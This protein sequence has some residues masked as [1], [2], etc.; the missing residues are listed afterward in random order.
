[1]TD[2][3]LDLNQLQIDLDTSNLALAFGDVVDGDVNTPVDEQPKNP[4]RSLPYYGWGGVVSG[5]KLLA[6]CQSSADV[7]T[8][9]QHDYSNTISSS[10]L[11]HEHL[12]SNVSSSVERHTHLHAYNGA[13]ELLVQYGYAITSADRQLHTYLYAQNGLDLLLVSCVDVPNSNSSMITTQLH[14]QNHGQMLIASHAVAENGTHISGCLKMSYGHGVQPPCNWREIPLDDKPKTIDYPCGKHPSSDNLP[15]EFDQY[16]TE[17]DS[18][19]ISFPFA[20]RA[21]NFIPNLTTYIMLNEITVTANG[22]T[23]TPFSASISASM[24]GYC[25]LGEVSLPPDDFAAL[26]LDKRIQGDELEIELTLNGEKF[27]FLAEQF[28]DSRQFGRKS[29]TVSGRS[30]TAHLG[31]DYAQIQNGVVNQRFYAQQIASAVLY[32]TSFSLGNWTAVDWL[33]P[34]NVYSLS[35]KTPIAVLQDIA[36]AAGAF[37]E[38]DP[39]E[40]KI[41]IAPR[42]KKA[43]WE[44]VD[45]VVDVRCPADIIIKISGQKQV[46]TQ[47][48]SVFTYPTH[49]L[50]DAGLVYRSGS[51]KMPQAPMLSHALYTESNVQRAAGLATL[52]ESGVHKT[53][54]V[55]LAPPSEKYAIPRAKLGQIWR[56]DEPDGAWFGVVVGVKLSASVENGAPKIT[57]TLTVDRYL[58][59]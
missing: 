15:F 5:S 40:R 37:L 27:V 9:I 50:N 53:E 56:F 54:T 47:Y 8:A 32:D 2:F 18:A 25:W 16:Q 14:G 19:H 7:D 57:Q 20:C 36:Q 13:N 35:D 41:H 49:E 58:G 59:D 26:A 6:H 34:E 12:L 38:S 42:W 55:E 23:L 39:S 21:E 1:M 4:R 28:S 29:Y 11:V 44:L 48:R 30:P 31:A 46:Q 22:R 3:K 52:S 45:S 17:L 24:D 33:V 43:A 10:V 51:D